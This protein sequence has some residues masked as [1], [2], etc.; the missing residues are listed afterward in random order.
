MNF[1]GEAGG[2]VNEA[3]RSKQAGGQSRPVKVAG[4]IRP[5]PVPWNPCLLP[6]VSMVLDH[7]AMQP[8]SHGM[9]PWS[10][11]HGQVP[12]ATFSCPPPWTFPPAPF[13]FYFILFFQTP[14][15]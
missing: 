7:A 12:T 14:L 1:M 6:M 3:G 2:Q 13:L 9:Q 15:C 5:L 11:W 4:I 10:V 8:C